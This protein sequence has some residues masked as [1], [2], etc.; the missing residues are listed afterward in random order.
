MI[1]LNLTL[2]QHEMSSTLNSSI[3]HKTKHKA[4][5]RQA[6]NIKTDVVVKQKVSFKF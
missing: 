2:I 6:G 4:M 1:K 5:I 3:A